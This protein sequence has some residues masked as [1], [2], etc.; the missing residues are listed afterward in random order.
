MARS[1]SRTFGAVAV[2]P[3]GKHRP[4][5]SLQYGA[6]EAVYATC[7]SSG[8]VFAATLYG[9]TAIV[10]AFPVVGSVPSADRCSPLGQAETPAV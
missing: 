1:T 9:S 8:N 7:D 10:V 2:F 4:T 3:H 6:A 5:R